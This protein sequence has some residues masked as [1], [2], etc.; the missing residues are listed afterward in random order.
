MTLTPTARNDVLSAL[1]AGMVPEEFWDVNDDLCDC[2]FQRIGMWTNPYLGETLEVRMCCIWAEFYKL[3]PQ[4]VRVIPAFLDYNKDEW[5]TEAMEWNGETDMPKPVW[6]RQIARREGISVTEARDRYR[7]RDGE[8]PRGKGPLTVVGTGS[9][10]LTLSQ[11]MALEH[12]N[13][14]LAA[15]QGQM[16]A[17]LM[18]AGLDPA[19][20]YHISPDGE[21]TE[22]SDA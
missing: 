22:V 13:G 20:T 1:G 11:R 21:A 8:R 4:F 7:G 16:G 17:I 19:K 3:F 5:V 14:Q 18:E 6:Y 9:T 2:T 15:L 10:W 12:L